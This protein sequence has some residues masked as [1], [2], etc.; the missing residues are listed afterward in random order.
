MKKINDLYDFI[1]R[2]IKSRKYPENTG[3]SLKSALKLFE[4]ELNEDEK[5]SLDQFKRNIEQIYQT[6]FSK[7]KE[8]SA[9]SLAVYKSRVLKAINDYEKYGTDPNKM[10]NW[11]PKIIIRTKRQQN[12]QNNDMLPNQNIHDSVSNDRKTFNFTDSGS[13]WSMTIK[14]ER[15]LS[16]EIKK[17]LIDISELLEKKLIK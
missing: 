2:A 9:D 10:A 5:N 13:D 1:E 4:R 15:Q 3:L 7:N 8:Y 16:A 12:N 11:I 6:V 14:S 17:K